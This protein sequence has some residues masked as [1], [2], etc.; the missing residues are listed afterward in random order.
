MKIKIEH[1]ELPSSHKGLCDNA[2]EYTTHK[3]HP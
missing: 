2:K 3:I 1:M